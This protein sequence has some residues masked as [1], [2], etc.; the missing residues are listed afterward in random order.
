MTVSWMKKQLDVWSRER[1][2]FSDVKLSQP[3]PLA[4]NLLVGQDTALIQTSW[5]K[6]Q[7]SALSLQ[8]LPQRYC[9]S[10]ALRVLMKK[11]R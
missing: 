4:S 3:C 6:R 5:M 1:A 11:L 8:V 10:V 2:L 7:R 9:E